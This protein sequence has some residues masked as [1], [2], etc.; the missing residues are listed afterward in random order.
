MVTPKEKLNYCESVSRSVVSVC[1]PHGLWP[2]GILCPWD[3]PGKNTGAHSQSLL[4][5]IFPT[6]V[7]CI[8]GRVFTV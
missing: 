3:S 6:W 5:G 1:D 8:P 4:Q 2:T 7:S